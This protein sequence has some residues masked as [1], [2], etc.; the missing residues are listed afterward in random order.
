VAQDNFC[1]ILFKIGKYLMSKK[2]EDLFDLPPAD[3]VTETVDTSIA[4]QES[5]D[6]QQALADADEA[7]DKIDV[8]LPT[9]RDLDASDKDMDDLADL[10]QTTFK[11]LMDLAM[12]VEPRFSGP[13]IQSASTLLGHAVTAKVAKM[14]KKLKMI[15]LQLKKARLD[16]METKSTETPIQAEGIV[17]DRNELLKTILANSKESK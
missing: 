4:L 2:L 5:H 6:M 12:N 9:V 15:D 8:A 16:K 7:I 14:D 13:I 17:L 3:S 10:A 11:D 1:V